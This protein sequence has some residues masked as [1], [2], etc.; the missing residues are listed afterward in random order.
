M[1]TKSKYGSILNSLGLL[2]FLLIVGVT[3]TKACNFKPSLGYK[4]TD[5]AF[6]FIMAGGSVNSTISWDFGD[7][8]TALGK[9]YPQYV[10]H[11]YAQNGKYKVK[12]FYHDTIADCL[13]TAIEE[14]CYFVLDS[15]PKYKRSGDT[16]IIT[17]NGCQPKTGYRWY[18]SDNTYSWGCNVRHRFPNSGYYYAQLLF[19]TDSV[20]GCSYYEMPPAKEMDFTKCGFTAKF[21]NT[22]KR[23]SASVN[24]A[25]F[26]SSVGKKP[27]KETWYWG[28]GKTTTVNKIQYSSINHP[29][30]VYGNYTICHVLEDSITHCKD[31]ACQSV[32][33]DSC[34]A[35]S[36]FSYMV[37]ERTIKLKNE[38]NNFTYDWYLNGV[39]KAKNYNP[40]LTVNKNGKYTICLVTYGSDNCTKT[41]CQEITVRVCDKLNYVSSSWDQNDCAQANLLIKDSNYAELLWV[42]DDGTTATGSN[43][44]HSFQYG[45]HSVKLIG[46]DTSVFNCKDSITFDINNACCNVKDSLV[47]NFAGGSAKTATI[48]NF[49]YIKQPRGPVHKHL[50]IFGDGASSTDPSP[51]HT[52]TQSGNIDAWYIGF[53]TV[54]NC[55]DS[56]YFTFN[57]DGSATPFVLN[58]NYHQNFTGLKTI[59][60]NSHFNVFPNPFNGQQLT[61]TSNSLARITSVALYDAIGRVYGLSY[62]QDNNQYQLQIETELPVGIYFIYLNTNNGV[63]V[64]KI[65]K[66]Q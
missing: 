30:A 15:M 3:E 52:Y 58:T 26:G 17:N 65:V 8:T 20:T 29:Y 64:V 39:L 19:I 12:M 23:M 47:L 37:A 35:I 21:N 27:G 22:P 41:S 4:Q 59:H 18:F 16:L 46:T 53:D 2:L 34:N 62:T 55:V 25:P 56:M 63:E 45:I 5:S 6:G 57:I 14:I 49:S 61:I 13:D 1:N 44:K 48:E 50:W 38:S 9:T 36:K 42:F 54:H 33:V 31:S 51:S 24:T 66:G 40:E 60:T 28:N 32:F 11:K 7:G 43:P 10:Y